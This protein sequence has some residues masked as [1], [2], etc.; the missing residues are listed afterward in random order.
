MTTTEKHDKFDSENQN[1]NNE[2]IMKN[3]FFNYW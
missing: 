1:S 3:T 2:E